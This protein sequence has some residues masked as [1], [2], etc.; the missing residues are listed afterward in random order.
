MSAPEFITDSLIIASATPKRRHIDLR[1]SLAA[2]LNEFVELGL[3]DRRTTS[4]GLTVWSFT[5]GATVA[6]E[7]FY[8]D[9]FQ[10]QFV[11][12]RLTRDAV[13]GVIL[14]ARHIGDKAAMVR[15]LRVCDLRS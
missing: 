12:T 15:A 11:L 9:S 10:R 2:A 14:R 7:G 8:L 4:D 6:Q 1:V 5:D 13:L 3:F